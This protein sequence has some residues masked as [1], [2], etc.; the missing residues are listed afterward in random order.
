MQRQQLTDLQ[1]KVLEYI[2]KYNQMNGTPPTLRE[3]S[4]GFGWK[5]VGSAQDMVSALRKRKL[6][7]DA[8][9]GKSRQIYLSKMGVEWMALHG[10]Q[11]PDTASGSLVFPPTSDL[12][13]NDLIKVPL[14]GRVQAGVPQNQLDAIQETCTFL[15]P[16]GFSRAAQYFAL[17]VE[18]YSMVQ[19]GFNPGDLLLVE[20]M[21]QAKNGDIVVASVQDHQFTV[22]RFA[23]RGSQLYRQFM[24]GISPTTPPK[25]PTGALPPVLL[26]PENPE[27][28][29]IPFGLGEGDRILGLVRSL[30]R[31]EV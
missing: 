26:V 23:M 5:A 28:E 27:F 30:Y 31:K 12:L 8:E 10:E 18:G 14:L 9:P 1:K 2:Y 20:K 29:A 21:E 19:A 6:L 24:S 4:T 25:P 16:S 22:K 15:A 3:L 11:V 17:E 7:V 13:R